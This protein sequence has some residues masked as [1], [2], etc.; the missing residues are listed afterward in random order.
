MSNQFD[1]Q[2][3][4]FSLVRQKQFAAAEDVAHNVLSQNGTASWAY[5]VL[6]KVY[7]H[8]DKHQEAIQAY[9]QALQIDPLLD[10]AYVGLSGSFA[11]TGEFEQAERSIAKA[12]ELNPRNQD[13]YWNEVGIYLLQKK[14]TSAQICVLEGF[15]TTRS[16]K[17][18]V[19]AF[20]VYLQKYTIPWFLV[21][22]CMALLS[23]FVI[24]KTAWGLV[25]F[26]LF[27]TLNLLREMVGYYTTRSNRS[28]LL[29]MASLSIMS[30]WFIVVRSTP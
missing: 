4:V 25:L 23:L 12:K 30:V 19:L 8:Q 10:Q 3:F 2:S 26:I 16:L 9:M 18:A 21:F 20:H 13:V 7:A 5:I 11:N 1:Q 29:F 27:A 24:P 22:F 15:R 28:L 14:L 6:G 17:L